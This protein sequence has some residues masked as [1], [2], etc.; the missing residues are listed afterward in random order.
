MHMTRRAS[1]I[2]SGLGGLA[3]HETHANDVASRI[4]TQVDAAAS[5]KDSGEDAG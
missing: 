2:R 4:E 5:L 1:V 3:G